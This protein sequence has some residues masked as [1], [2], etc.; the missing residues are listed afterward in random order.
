MEIPPV[1]VET[2]HRWTEIA[3][4]TPE[5]FVR[6]GANPEDAKFL[7]RARWF[8]R[9]LLRVCVNIEPFF[10][11]SSLGYHMSISKP[12]SLP[13]WEEITRARYDLLPDELWM[14]QVLPPRKSYVNHHPYTMHLFESHE[15]QGATTG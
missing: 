13:T 15:A 12:A 5:T 7:G 14:V 1:I 10:A 6:Q 3:G 4:L 8:R 2:S 9:G 11:D